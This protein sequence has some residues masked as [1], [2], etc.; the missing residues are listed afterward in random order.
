[1]EKDTFLFVQNDTNKISTSALN[2]LI[3]LYIDTIMEHE[4]SKDK[5]TI[6]RYKFLNDAQRSV[7]TMVQGIGYYKLL[8]II[9]YS[10]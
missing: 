2:N 7:K 8:K 1:M 5:K 4:K 3:Y 6:K 10:I 9:E